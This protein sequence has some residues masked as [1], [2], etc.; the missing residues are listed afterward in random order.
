MKKRILILVVVLAAAL[1]AVYWFYFRDHKDPNGAIRLSGNIEVT[2]VDL[3][4]KIPGRLE[5]RLVDEGAAVA[6][7]QLVANLEDADER[8]GV[9]K[10]DAD[11]ARAKAVLA[12]L[13]AGSRPQEIQRAKAA[14]QRAQ[15]ALLELETGS[16]SQEIAQAK[17]DLTRVTAARDAANSRLD[18]ARA[19]FSRYA[20]VYKQGGVSAQ[21]YDSYKTRLDTAQKA[22]EEAQAALAAAKQRYSLVKEGPRKEQI[23]QARAALAAAEAE[24]ALVEAGPRQEVID[25][26]GAQVEAAKTALDLARRRLAETRLYC[27]FDAVVLSKSAEPGAY[28]TPGAPVVT[29]GQMA[30]VRLRAFIL[31]SQLGKIRLGQKADVSIDAFPGKTYPGVVSYISQEAEFTPKSV[32]TFEERVHLVYR[33]KIDLD[34]ESGDLKAGM[35]ADARDTG[36]PMN[37]KPAIFCRDLTRKFNGQNRRGPC[38]P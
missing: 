2:Q 13:L 38:E 26:A 36:G 14:V 33:I 6:A 24:S 31:E 20:A 4:F 32:Q 1:G 12:E 8:L 3:S 11:L 16:R 22:F 17:A 19:D 23:R 35:P 5:K 25:Q 10:A 37:Q 28:M 18:Q 29:V 15:M 30:R 27:P 34:N 7:G 9:Q 21:A